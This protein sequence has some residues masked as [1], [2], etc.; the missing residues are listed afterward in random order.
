LVTYAAVEQK[1][2][3]RRA[4]ENQEIARVRIQHRTIAIF[5]DRG[6]LFLRTAA[7]GLVAAYIVHAGHQMVEKLANGKIDWTAIAT[8]VLNGKASNIIC[9]LV[10]AL[11]TGV[12]IYERHLRHTVTASQ[13]EYV[14]K[15]EQIVDPNRSS[16]KLPPTGTSRRGDLE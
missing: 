8:A 9:L 4:R 1:A 14:K 3:R 15:L 13:A 5:F 16:S 10:A 7:K 6:F 12:A 11:A 2:L